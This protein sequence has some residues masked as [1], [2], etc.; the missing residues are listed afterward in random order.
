MSGFKAS[1]CASVALVVILAA[2]PSMHSLSGDDERKNAESLANGSRTFNIGI[3]GYAVSVATLNPFTYTT[4][5]EY[6]TIWPCYST[7]LTNDENANLI[8]DLATSWRVS[9]NGTLWHFAIASNASFVDPANPTD[10][11]HQVTANDVFWTLWECQNDTSNHL[12]SYFNDAGQPIIKNMWTGSNLFDIYIETNFVYAPFLGALTQIPIVPKYIWTNLDHYTPRT[13]PNLPI[14]GS[15]PFYYSNGAVLPGQLAVLKRNPIWFQEDNRGWQIHIDTLNFKSEPDAETA[16]HDL[17]LPDPF[18]DTY[19]NVEPSVYLANMGLPHPWP[20]TMGFA[21]STGFIYEYQ[22]NQLTPLRRT[23]LENAGLMGRNGANNPLMSDA[24]IKLALAMCVDKQEFVNQVLSGLGSVAD[25]LVPDC[26]RWHYT[27]PNPVQFNTTAAR[28]LL[29]DAGWAYDSTGAYSPGALPLYKKGASNDTVYWP[30]AFN[31]FTFNTDSLWLQGANLL[32]QWAAQ[33]GVE[34]TLRLYSVHEA[35]S[36]W[37]T[38]NYDAWLWDWIFTPTSDPSTDCLSVDTTMAIGTWSGS[39]WSNATFDDLYNR[40]L[41]ATTDS[42]RRVLTDKMQALLY[43]D[44]ND[45]LVAYAKSLHG[46]STV[47]YA[48]ASYGDW[49]HHWA[50]IPE[51]GLPWLYMRLS[52]VD[53]IAPN[54]VVSSPTGYCGDLGAPITFS[55]TSSQT[56]DVQYQWY[57]GD[58]TTSGWLSS[59]TTTHAYSTWGLFT[60][61]FAVK[62]T[63]TAD[64]FMGWGQTHATVIIPGNAPPVFGNPPIIATPST[65]ITTGMTVYFQANAFDVNGDAI[66]YSW[67]FGDTYTALGAIATHKYTSAGAYTVTVTITDGLEGSPAQTATK[68]VPVALNVPPVLSI[69]PYKTV[70]KSVLTTFNATASDGNGDPLRYTWYWGDGPSGNPAGPPTVTTVPLAQH[71][72]TLYKTYTLELYADDL[73][74]LLGH[75]VSVTQIVKADG[76]T[77]PTSVTDVVTPHAY[78]YAGQSLT[79]TGSAQDPGG[80]AMQFDFVFGDGTDTIVNNPPTAANQVVTNSSTHVYAAPGT[81]AAYMSATDG[82]S[83]TS[84]PTIT[85]T[86]NLNH[87]P[88]MPPQTAKSANQRVALSFSA[89]ATDLD[90]DPL[91]YTWNFGD[92]SALVVNRTATH[93]YMNA[94]YYNFTVFVDDLTGLP[95]HNVSSS[96]QASI[97]FNLTLVAG[98]NLVTIPVVGYGYKASNV[99]LS[100]GDM[101]CSWNT[102]TQAYN[103]TYI[104]GISGSGADFAIQPNTGYWVWVA[105]QRTL[106]LYGGAPSTTQTVTVTVPSSGGWVAIGLESQKTTMR[107]SD[108]G[109]TAV[110]YFNATSKQYKTWLSAVP[111]LNNF[112]LVPGQAYWCWY[113]ASGVVTYNPQ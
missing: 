104:K 29:N 103:G 62:Q 69:A 50:L 82:L 9:P 101:I 70:I 63:G 88:S 59:P 65:G 100:T 92:G 94:G 10:T 84:S 93:K 1:V 83:T 49:S 109:A 97:A 107:A 86:V 56:A 52:P 42:A 41:L 81:F 21:Q 15:G 85:I 14:I 111:M 46:A 54:A 6:E 78:C 33:A 51:F 45:Q 17:T 113:P 48:Q 61:Y 16:W 75:N 28:K 105:A 71:T 24:T 58:G 8:G 22:L 102:T 44:H 47:H 3:V 96:A 25:S 55:G 87:T 40:S 43:E 27:Y 89:S 74:G 35:N 30:L 60:V 106:H 31:M 95:G 99:G 32:I 67:D 76:V 2:I 57:W 11:S 72:Y 26:S 98:W 64:G 19:L 66:Y 90:S 23:Q 79:F 5:A 108:L 7:L 110:S 36:A 91:R 12:W 34:Y 73:T 13:F 77:P 38:G 39:Y 20:N 18:I 80:D 68:E 37:Y 4:S 53:N 112:P